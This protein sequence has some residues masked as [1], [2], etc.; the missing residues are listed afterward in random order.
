MVILRRCQL[1]VRTRCTFIV[2]D[3][4][5]PSRVTPIISHHFRREPFP[6]LNVE[7]S[8]FSKVPAEGLSPIPCRV[9][10]CVRG[11][12][13]SQG[14]FSRSLL[15]AVKRSAE[16]FV[17]CWI[18]ARSRP[19][20]WH[21]NYRRIKSLTHDNPR[22][23]ATH[24]ELLRPLFCRIW[25]CGSRGH[26][27]VEIRCPLEGQATKNQPCQKRNAQRFIPPPIQYISSSSIIA[28]PFTAPQ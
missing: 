10:A 11:N 18:E 27:Q 20:R 23:M 25:F 13:E 26:G 15:C 14:A 6:K 17:P 22:G 24:F 28:L 9:R 4:L 3:D 16:C 1:H 2:E 8:P 7:C 5:F 12:L 21:S 19:T